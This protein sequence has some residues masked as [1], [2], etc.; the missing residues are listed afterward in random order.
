[1]KCELNLHIFFQIF[2]SVVS[3]FVF[4]ISINIESSKKKEKKK[5][6][7]FSVK[8]QNKK[9]REYRKKERG[10]ESDMSE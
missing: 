6:K 2:V 7:A 8:I 10:R 4:L 9:G 3:R 5:S 1:M